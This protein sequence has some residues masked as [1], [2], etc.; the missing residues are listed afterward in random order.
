M[1]GPIG[2]QLAGDG[3]VSPVDAWLRPVK[4]RAAPRLA[5]VCVP[6]AGGGA[7][8]FSAWPEILP[9]EVE[10]LA[11]QLPGRETR[12]GEVPLRAFEPIVDAVVDAIGARVRTPYALYGHS[13]G[14]LLAFEVTRRIQS[15]RLLHLFVAGCRAPQLVPVGR[16]RHCLPHDELLRWLREL[17]G[18]AAEVV[19][20]AELM[21]LLMPALRADLAVTDRYRYHLGPPV[22]VDLTA[23]GGAADPEVPL[24]ALSAWSRQTSGRFRQHTFPGGHF[25]VTGA[26]SGMLSLMVDE[27]A[28]A[29]EG[30]ASRP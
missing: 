30:A 25:F 19:A 13:M 12:F 21:R 16:R 7:T 6:H 11:V 17:D 2:R 26:R 23:F 15:R 4:A 18:T 10:V 3:P 29:L 28:P 8:A 20:H 24:H 1:P 9:P 22:D 5:L 27:L 14:A